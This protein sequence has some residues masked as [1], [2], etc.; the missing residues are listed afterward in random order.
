MV[1]VDTLHQGDG[2]RQDG[3][4]AFDDAFHHLSGRQVAAAEAF[5]LQVGVH[6]RGLFHTAI[7]LQTGKF[8]TVLGMYHIL[9]GKSVK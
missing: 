9:K 2:L 7:D 4:I 6:D 5:T 3:D 8:G 1:G